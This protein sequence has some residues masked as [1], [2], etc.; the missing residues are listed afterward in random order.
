MT[1]VFE[2]SDYKIKLNLEEIFD[3]ICIRNDIELFSL[4]FA[5]YTAAFLSLSLFLSVLIW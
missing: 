3:F 2:H 4:V 1:V 5:Y